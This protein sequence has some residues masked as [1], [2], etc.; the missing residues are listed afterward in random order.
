MNGTQRADISIGAEVEIVLKG[1]STNWN[2]NR[3]N[4]N[5]YSHKVF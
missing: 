3:R 1:R 2:F 4:C 5:E